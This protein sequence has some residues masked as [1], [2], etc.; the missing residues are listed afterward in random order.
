MQ[1]YAL[2]DWLRNRYNGFLPNTY[3]YKDIYVQSADV[4]RIL[5]SADMCLVGLY[6]SHENDTL[7]E[8]QS[9][10]IHTTPEE[11]DNVNLPKKN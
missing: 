6:P 5:I 1:M 11:K 4:D 8:W 2:G 3:S 7:L 10:P 9:I